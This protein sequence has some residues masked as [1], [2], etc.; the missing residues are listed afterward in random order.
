MSSQV[1]PLIQRNDAL[2]NDTWTFIHPSHLSLPISDLIHPNHLQDW[3]KSNTPT[4]FPYQPSIHPSHFRPNAST[5]PSYS[6]SSINS[7]H[8]LTHTLNHPRIH[9]FFI[10]NFYFHS[11]IHPCTRLPSIHPSNPFPFHPIHSFTNPSIT[12]FLSNYGFIC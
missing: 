4:I 12:P 9:P 7:S 2:G 5:Y 11:S 10:S 3:C 6:I 1:Q 8:P